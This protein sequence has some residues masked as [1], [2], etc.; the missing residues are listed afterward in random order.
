[1]SPAARSSRRGG[2]GSRLA[3]AA[4]ERERQLGKRSLE[5]VDF[6]ALLEQLLFAIDVRL[7]QVDVVVGE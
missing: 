1:M 7:N 6:A 5:R 3:I 4:C 2:F